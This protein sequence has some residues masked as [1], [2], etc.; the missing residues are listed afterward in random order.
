MRHTTRQLSWGEVPGR[1]RCRPRLA[2]PE[3]VVADGDGYPT[4]VFSGPRVLDPRDRGMTVDLAQDGALRH[5]DDDLDGTIGVVTLL[6][7]RTG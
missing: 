1:C 6:R 2:R 4:Q 5:F 3:D 7:E